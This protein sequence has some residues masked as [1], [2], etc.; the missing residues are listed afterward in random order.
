MGRLGRTRIEANTTTGRVRGAAQEAGRVAVYKGVPYAAPPIGDRRWKPPVAAEPWSGVRD[1][2]RFGPSAHQRVAGFEEFFDGLVRGLGLGVVRRTVLGA[3]IKLAPTKQSEDCLTLNIRTP[4]HASGLPVMV[5][6]HG[7]DHTDGS[8][9]EPMYQSNVFPERGCVLVTINYRLGLFG[10]FAHPELSAE[11]DEGVSSNYGLLDQIAALE[12]VRDNIA[13]FGGDPGSV[14]I[15]GESAGGE[16]VLNL[17]TSPRARGLFQRAIA[18]SPSDSG[19]WL[20]LDRPAVDFDPAVDAGRRFADA[21]VGAGGGQVER[22]RAMD[23]EA[24]SDLYRERADLGRY[25]YPVVDGVVLPTAPMNAFSAGAQADVP[26]LIGYNSDE[27]SLLATFM[28]PAGAEFEAPADGASVGRPQIR[29]AFERSYPTGEHVD[30]LFAEYP[31]LA[32]GE[33]E[34]SSRHAG[35]HM[36]GVHVDHASR[37]HAA[38]GHPVYRYHFRAVPASKRQTAGAFHAAE[39]LYVFDTSFPLVPAA[40]D[41]HLLVRDMGD[42]WFAFA[43]TGVP[44]APGREHWPAYDV[45]DPRHMVFDRPISAVQQC[46]AQPGLDLMRERIEWLTGELATPVG[47]R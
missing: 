24:L 18:Q 5:W 17:M 30:R 23:P 43:A 36:F 32:A 1:C 16:A 2:R 12:W 34:A 22:L 40:E 4:T 39:V 47:A 11:S 41:A 37:C 10:F 33:F 35:D 6:I 27:G 3:A 25:F 28:H 14:T 29:A 21:A 15:F 44:D 45:D 26:L 20:H 19:R 46:P 38:Q 8:G 42:R 31:G 9:S 13:N 7:G